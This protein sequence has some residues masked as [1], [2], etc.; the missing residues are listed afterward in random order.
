MAEVLRDWL[1]VAGIEAHNLEQDFANGYLFGKLLHEYNLQPHLNTFVNKGKPD[2][3][4]K[5]Y[6]MLQPVLSKL[7]VQFDTRTAQALINKEPGLAAKVLYAIKQSL[8]TMDKNTQALDH[9]S[10]T[11]HQFGMRTSPSRGMLDSQ[12]QKTQHSAY[13]A[14]NLQL[15]EDIMRKRSESPNKLMQTLHVKRF[16]DE[17]ERQAAAAADAAAAEAIARAAAKAAARIEELNKLAAARADKAAKLQRDDAV[18]AALLKHQDDREKQEL[19]VEMALSKLGRYRQQEQ[20]AAAA[21]DAS[22]GI[23]AFEMTLKRLGT[24]GATDSKNWF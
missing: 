7:G 12:H 21:V 2:A 10:R 18:H 23:D 13:E 19:R 9:T 22:S 6:V 8:G 5:N 20:R 1:L 16:I 3:Y 11:M 14:G 24:G 17:G 15:F 4:L